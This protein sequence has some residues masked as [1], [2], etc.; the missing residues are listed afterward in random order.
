[1]DLPKLAAVGLAVGLAACMNPDPGGSPNESPPDGATGTAGTSGSAGSGASGAG[2]SSGTSG[3]SSSGGSP[4]GGIACSGDWRN[5]C[6]NCPPPNVCWLGSLCEPPC[7]TYEDCE[8]DETCISGHCAP[9]TC[10]NADTSPHDCTAADGQHGTCVPISGTG[11]CVPAAGQPAPE[12]SPCS[13]PAAPQATPCWSAFSRGGAI[14]GTNQL[15]SALT[16]SDEG[17]CV[18]LCGGGG[19]CPTG[20]S[21]VTDFA[22][23]PYCARNGG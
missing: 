19:P 20:Q 21:C 2:G 11:V 16:R 10:A 22:G 9:T 15:C 5:G 7:A 18:Q 14:C 8:I 23:V 4:D 12:W 3:Q 6:E 13:P 1:M 17:V